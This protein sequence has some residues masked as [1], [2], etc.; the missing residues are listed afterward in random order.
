MQYEHHPQV[1]V[2]MHK[3]A[4]SCQIHH[5][6]ETALPGDHHGQSQ[7]FAALKLERST[8]SYAFQFDPY[9][10]AGVTVVIPWEGKGPE[11]TIGLVTCSPVTV[12]Q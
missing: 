12:R 6:S 11:V 1:S 2:V 8:L 9:T 4:L 7:H 5:Y 3:S 10:V